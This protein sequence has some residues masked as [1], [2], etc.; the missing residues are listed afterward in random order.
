[1]QIYTFYRCMYMRDVNKM[2]TPLL[3]YICKY[4]YK[5]TKFYIITYICNSF[6]SVILQ[7]CTINLHTSV[8]LIISVIPNR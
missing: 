1:M 4:K 5:C 2:P 7:L 3:Y 6:T 8:N